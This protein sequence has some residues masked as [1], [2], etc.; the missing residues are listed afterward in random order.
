MDKK[1]WESN[2]PRYTQMANKSIKRV[3]CLSVLKCILRKQWNNPFN[4]RDYQ[5]FKNHSCPDTNESV[6][7]ID[8]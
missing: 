3:L 7:D 6:K 2:S 5:R 8:L 4:V 1:T